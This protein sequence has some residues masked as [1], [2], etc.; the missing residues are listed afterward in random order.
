MDTTST[1]VLGVTGGFVKEAA[2][3]PVA[4]GDFFD[5]FI[6]REEG[7][8]TFLVDFGVGTF[9]SLLSV[10]FTEALLGVL[11]AFTTSVVVVEIFRL[12]GVAETLLVPFFM[13]LGA[14]DAADLLLVVTM[15]RGTIY[16]VLQLQCV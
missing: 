14:G 6:G 5:A 8:E 16:G 3:A 11:F 12:E 1:L 2:D 13:A 15:G 4:S 10:D 7:E 9:V